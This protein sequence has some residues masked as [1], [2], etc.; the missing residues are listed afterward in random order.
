[1]C[2]IF[3]NKSAVL[4]TLVMTS[5]RLYSYLGETFVAEISRPSREQGSI[6]YLRSEILAEC[7]SSDCFEYDSIPFVDTE[8][9]FGS[10]SSNIWREVV[11]VS[12]KTNH[13]VKPRKCAENNPSISNN[14]GCRV[15]NCPWGTS[16]TP[17]KY[18]KIKSNA[19]CVNIDQIKNIEDNT[20]GE[21]YDDYIPR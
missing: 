4:F 1:M 8:I 5:K 12:T 16:A 21:G 2:A 19:T 14:R 13:Q 15:L 11:Y 18:D 6:R 9:S 20:H 17:L 3:C 7:R 10:G